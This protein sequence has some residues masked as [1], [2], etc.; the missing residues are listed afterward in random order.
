M[1]LEVRCAQSNDRNDAIQVKYIQEM[2]VRGSKCLFDVV[3]G[4]EE[5]DILFQ[6]WKP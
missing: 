1:M 3:V 4:G 5:N 2:L 6:V